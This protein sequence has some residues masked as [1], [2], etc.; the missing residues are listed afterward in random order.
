MIPPG[1]SRFSS[2]SGTAISG[3]LTRTCFPIGA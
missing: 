2:A 1:G 3:A